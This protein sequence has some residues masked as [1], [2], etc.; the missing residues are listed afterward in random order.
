MAAANLGRDK[1]RTVLVV[2]SMTLSMVL[3]HSVYTFSIGFDMDKFL[4]K[5]IKTDFLVAH[6]SYF[7]YQYSGSDTS[8]PEHMIEEIVSQEGFE[9]GGR[10]YANIRDAEFFTADEVK[11]SRNF[12]RKRHCRTERCLALFTVWMISH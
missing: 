1:K 12:W 8:V 3:F 5:Y 9:E 7:G 10:M 2:L 4:S 11:G 6:A